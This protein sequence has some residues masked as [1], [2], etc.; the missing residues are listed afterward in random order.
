M[1]RITISILLLSIF[2]VMITSC[3]PKKEIE[4][5][6]IP[7]PFILVVY[8]ENSY[9]YIFHKV[10]YNTETKTMHEYTYYYQDNNANLL[11]RVEYSVYD[12]NGY[13]IG[14]MEE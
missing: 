13:L 14:P 10:L 9:G 1:K 2:L 8:E 3:Q 4:V 5:E 7:E 12:S 11:D 6:K